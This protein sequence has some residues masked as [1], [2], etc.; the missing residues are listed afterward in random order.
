MRSSNAAAGTSKALPADDLFASFRT[1]ECVLYMNLE[2][3]STPRQQQ[4]HA[5]RGRGRDFLSPSSEIPTKSVPFGELV[6]VK[7]HRALLRDGHRSRV[8]IGPAHL[9]PERVA[10]AAHRDYALA[11]GRDGGALARGG[12]LDRRVR[13]V[14][15]L[16]GEERAGHLAGAFFYLLRMLGDFLACLLEERHF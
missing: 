14:V 4:T 9:H 11:V 2:H 7:V 13:V 8:H 12:E 15:A 10:P 6:P 5:Q 3:H 1:M 16:D